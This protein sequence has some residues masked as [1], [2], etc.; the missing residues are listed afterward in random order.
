MPKATQLD[1]LGTTGSVGRRFAPLSRCTIHGTSGCS[2]LLAG[3]TVAPGLVRG[4]AQP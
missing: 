4:G 1:V 3:L 2:T